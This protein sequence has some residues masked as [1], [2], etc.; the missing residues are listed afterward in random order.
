MN[1]T[2]NELTLEYDPDADAAYLRIGT[3]VH[4]GEIASTREVEDG[5]LFD[6][7]AAGKLR[8]IEILGAGALLQAGVLGG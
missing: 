8:G 7:D 3:P 6:F 4:D 2:V 1:E 5:I